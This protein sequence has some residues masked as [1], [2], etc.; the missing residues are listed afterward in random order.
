MTDEAFEAMLPELAPLPLTGLRV[1]A[2][3]LRTARVPRYERLL[4]LLESSPDPGVHAQPAADQAATTR[5]PGL[6]QDI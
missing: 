4:E 6:E 5:D 1:V 2:R 3:H